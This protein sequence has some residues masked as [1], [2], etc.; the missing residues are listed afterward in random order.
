VSNATLSDQ[1]VLITGGGGFIGSH[2]AATLAQLNDVR[3]LDNFSTGERRNV[4]DGVNVID[5]DVCNEETVDAALSDVD[6]VFHE[7]AMVSVPESVEH[8]VD[9][10][11]LNGSAT[12]QL[13]DCARRHDVRV[14]LASSAAVYGN[15]ESV[16]ITEDATTDPASPYGFEKRLNEQY[17]Q[18]YTET[19]GLPTVPLRYFNVYGSRGLDGEYAGVIG[20]FVRQAQSGN[21]LTVEG[22]GEQTR[23]FIHV[24]DVVQANLLAATTDAVGRPFNVGTGRSVT[25]NHL[26]ET[27][28]DVVGTDVPIEHVPPRADDIERSEADLHNTR[29]LLGFDPTVSLHEGLERTLEADQ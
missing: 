29:N 21:P 17:A 28:R 2:I 20:T 19:Y 5:G 18:F 8:P 25:I 15:P 10:H 24:D 3:V 6:V 12:V 1:R 26:A 13:L 27:V 7:A 22:D 4:S 16:P 14:I 9:C 11:D 23:D